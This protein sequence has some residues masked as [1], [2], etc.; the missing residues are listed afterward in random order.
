MTQFDLTPFYRSAIGLDRMA[1][2]FD[3]LAESAQSQQPNW[4]P[5]NIEKEGETNYR[6]TAKAV[7]V[8][9]KR[10]WISPCMN[11]C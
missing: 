11:R 1:N 2:L 10:I 9:Q 4:P 8:F 3:S 7:P 5:Y 6:I